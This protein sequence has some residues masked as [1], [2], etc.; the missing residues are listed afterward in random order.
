VVTELI[1]WYFKAEGGRLLPAS[2]ISK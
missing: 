2:D 1:S